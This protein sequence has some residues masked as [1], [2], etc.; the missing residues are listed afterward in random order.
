MQIS[1]PSTSK[2]IY[3]QDKYGK[4]VDKIDVLSDDVQILE[5]K[6]SFSTAFLWNDKMDYTMMFEQGISYK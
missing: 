4:V 2:Y 1:K 3:V 5:R 6:I